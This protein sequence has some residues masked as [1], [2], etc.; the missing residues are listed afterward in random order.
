[1]IEALVVLT[2]ATYRLTRLALVE[3]GPGNYAEKARVW[4]V[5]RYDENHWINKGSS[6][7]FCVSFWAALIVACLPRPIQVALAAAAIAP[8]LINREFRTK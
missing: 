5:T 1:V 2:L 7:E 6:C 3:D 8:H 4:A